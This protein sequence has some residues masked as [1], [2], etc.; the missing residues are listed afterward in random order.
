MARQTTKKTSKLVVIGPGRWGRALG[1]TFSESFSEVHYLGRNSSPKEWRE[2]FTNKPLCLIATPFK[3]VRKVLQILSKKNISGVINAS[4]GIDR[5][6]LT[7]FSVM[8]KKYLKVAYASL[9]GPSFAKELKEKK[10]TVC[11]LAGKNRNFVGLLSKR[12]STSYFRLYSS[13]DPIGV[14]ACGALKNVFAIACG[15]SDGL[16]L[17]SNARA[18]LLARALHEMSIMVKY[19]GGKSE[20]VFGL[21]GVG[22]LWLTATGDKSRNRML[23]LRLA[24]GQKVSAALK[25]IKKTKGP[26]EGYY[27]VQQVYKISKK[28]KLAMPICE[29]VYRLCKSQQKPKQS[30]KALM[31]REI[32]AEKTL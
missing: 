30:I 27:T 7:T 20:T 24:K 6:S 17:G 3:E 5:N 32:K 23:G 28:Y 9:S 16:R 19:L 11:V 22:D 21:A 26:A 14:D 4:K 12:L 18:A 1:N 10:P 31:T 29:Q 13:T 15:V 8:A 2:A 25:A